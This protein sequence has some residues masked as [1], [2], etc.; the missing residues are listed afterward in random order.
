MIRRLAQILFHF[1]ELKVSSNVTQTKIR[2]ICNFF[3]CRGEKTQAYMLPKCAQPLS[4]LW[5]FFLMLECHQTQVDSVKCIPCSSPAALAYQNANYFHGWIA[6]PSL[7]PPLRWSWGQASTQDR[8][9][10]GGVPWQ[11]GSKA[12]APKVGRPTSTPLGTDKCTAKLT[13]EVAN[14]MQKIIWR[15]NSETQAN[16]L[17]RDGLGRVGEKLPQSQGQTETTAG[18]LTTENREISLVQ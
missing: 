13:H 3:F 2:R 14:E 12:L 5:F 1:N 6:E 17:W 18:V 10:T 16:M 9:A 15:S 8:S 11:A 7:K 4:S